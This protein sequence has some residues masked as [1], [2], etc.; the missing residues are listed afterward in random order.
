MFIYL[1]MSLGLRVIHKVRWQLFVFFWPPTPLCWHFLPYKRWQKSQH[2]WTSYPPLLVN[3]VCKR[4]LTQNGRGIQ[5]FIG[6]TVNFR[7]TQEWHAN[8]SSNKW[9]E[10]VS[11]LF[12][13]DLSSKLHS[14]FTSNMHS[15]W[16]GKRIPCI[17]K[18]DPRIILVLQLWNLNFHWKIILAWCNPVVVV[19]WCYIYEILKVITI[20]NGTSKKSSFH[21]K[22]FF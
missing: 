13:W 10:T 8:S 2:F 9:P 21:S 15:L 3:V 12:A 19:F 20:T 14:D 1:R 17:M 22:Y 16:G 7:V 4:Q 18:L 5:T 11:K 6:P